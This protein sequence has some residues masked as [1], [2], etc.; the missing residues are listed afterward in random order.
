[1]GVAELMVRFTLPKNA[2]ITVGQTWARPVSVRNPREYRVYRWNP[3]D[4]K[5]PRM[6][7]YF[8]DRDGGGPMAL[9]AQRST[10]CWATHFAVGNG[11]TATC[12]ISRLMCRITKKT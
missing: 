2:K 9:D 3:D 11:V 6:D 8:V 10:T 7:T 5:N 4:A 12:R 1:M